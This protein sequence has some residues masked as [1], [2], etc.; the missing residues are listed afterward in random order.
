[1]ALDLTNATSAQ[2]LEACPH[3]PL[4]LRQALTIVLDNV[5]IKSLN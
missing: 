3:Y 4:P 1:M 5:R 2:T